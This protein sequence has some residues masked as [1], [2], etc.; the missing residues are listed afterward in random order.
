MSAEFIYVDM[1]DNE[2]NALTQNHYLTKIDDI[3][4]IGV[5]NPIDEFKDRLYVQP[6]VIEE[7]PT[8]APIVSD[9]SITS[10]LGS[11]PIT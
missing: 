6:I 3:I 7:I 4:A 2:V 9:E 10:N 5:S 8:D 11:S 1:T